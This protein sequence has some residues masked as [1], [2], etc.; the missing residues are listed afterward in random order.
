MTGARSSQGSLRL[1]KL[2]EFLNE[3]GMFPLISSP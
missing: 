2:G 3:D 1:V